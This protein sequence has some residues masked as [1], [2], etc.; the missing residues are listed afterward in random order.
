[1][2]Q[3]SYIELDF[4]SLRKN[5]RYL[6]QKI[7]GSTKFVSVIKGNAYGH[8]IKSFV[9][10]AEACGINY[11]AVSDSYE[12]EIASSVLSPDSE[13]MIM[14]MIDKSNLPWAIEMGISV[15]I[16]TL[17]RL[18]NIISYSRKLKKKAKIHIELETGL[19]R[20]GL[21]KDE[22]D[23]AIELIKKN[24]KNLIIEG[25]CT[26]YAG[27]ES[28][29]NYVRIQNQYDKF[30]KAISYLNSLGLHAF[31][32]HTASSAASLLYPYTR[33]NMVRIGIAQFGLWPSKETKIYTLYDGESKLFHN[34]L[35]QIIQW[36]SHILSVKSVKPAEF[37]GYGNSYLTTRTNRIAVIPIGY[38]HG[39]RR[40][41]SNIGFVL[42][43]G[44]KASVIGMI[45]MNMFIVDITAIPDV[46]IGDEVVLIGKQGKNKI[47][48]ASFSELMN[49]VNYELLTRL[50]NEI[51]R[52][53]IKR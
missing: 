15:Y 1:M 50:P 53:I 30:N 45:N 25:F 36:K 28:I 8:G 26:H 16:F 17:E 5:I 49:L 34:P 10:L 51:P 21:D 40:S 20:T 23:E 41:L 29:S 48:V 18:Q 22:L 9:P 35:K 2:I 39:F 33:M 46:K 7:G 12:A 43:G 24:R 3:S 11:F 38:Y 14:G 6:Q 32:H 19:N 37:I 27:A 13:L 44:R 47:T 52:K 42:I 31:Y 4:T